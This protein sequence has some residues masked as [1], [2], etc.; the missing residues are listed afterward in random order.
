MSHHMQVRRTIRRRPGWK[1]IH[2]RQE[3]MTS[4]HRL[5][6]MKSHHKRGRM[7]NHHMRVQMKIHHKQGQTI[8]CTLERKRI[9]TQALRRSCCRQTQTS[10]RRQ[11]QKMSR[12]RL[13]RTKIHHMPG[14][15]TIHHMPERKMIHGNP[16]RMK[17][18]HRQERTGSTDGQGSWCKESTAQQAWSWTGSGLRRALGCQRQWPKGRTGSSR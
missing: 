6:L 12:H 16:G 10:H 5:G 14:R 2:H 13:E 11:A 17:S 18:H 1:K 3:R 7:M 15:R 8:R 9:H 4:H